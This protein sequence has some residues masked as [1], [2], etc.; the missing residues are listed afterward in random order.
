MTLTAQGKQEQ[1]GRGV[2]FCAM[3]TFLICGDRL[4]RQ[5]VHYF[6]HSLTKKKKP[7]KISAWGETNRKPS[8]I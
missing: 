5:S 4:H 6:P 1:D 3:G 7:K 2:V 8:N